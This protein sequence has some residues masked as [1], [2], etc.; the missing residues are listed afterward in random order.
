MLDVQSSSEG[1]LRWALQLR[2]RL[3]LH[4]ESR[5]ILFCLNRRN[6]EAS[7]PD[8]DGALDL[9]GGILRFDLQAKVSCFVALDRGV[10][11]QNHILAVVVFEIDHLAAYK[12]DVWPVLREAGRW[13]VA[14]GDRRDLVVVLGVPPHVSSIEQPPFW[15]G[16]SPDA[17]DD[18]LLLPLF[19]REGAEMNW[20]GSVPAG[21]AR[22][23]A[24]GPK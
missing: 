13:Q 19:G 12:F 22:G 5:T 16:V 8:D 10:L 21:R 6:L 15:L 20:A 11:Q 18:R 14:L 23:T 7:F 1:T 17:F 24:Q 2:V 4:D 9:R 3:L